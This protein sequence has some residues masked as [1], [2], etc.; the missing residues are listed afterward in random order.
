MKAFLCT[1]FTIAILATAL[2]FGVLARN[3]QTTQLPDLTKPSTITLRALPRQGTVTSIWLHIH[4]HIEG[5]A[6]VSGGTY[7]APRTVRG[8]IDIDTTTDCYDLY[9]EFRYAPTDVTSGHLTIDYKF[10]D[11]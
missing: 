9:F 2:V 10:H 6:T 4:G 1:L 8:D 11:L 5:S 7:F 3:R